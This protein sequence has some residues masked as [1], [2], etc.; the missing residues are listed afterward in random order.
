MRFVKACLLSALTPVLL[1]VSFLGSAQVRAAPS[2]RATLSGN[3]PPWARSAS[4]KSAANLSDDV[5]FRVYLNWQNPS[6]LEALDRAVAA[7]ASPSYGHY[8]TPAQF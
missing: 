6:G 1:L 2:N 4:F 3:V 8:L 7:P 5:G